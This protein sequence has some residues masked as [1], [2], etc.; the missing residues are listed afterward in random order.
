MDQGTLSY[1]QMQYPTGTQQRMKAAMSTIMKNILLLDDL[2]GLAAGIWVINTLICKNMDFMNVS[3][4]N[5]LSIMF[6][7]RQMNDDG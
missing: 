3:S 1:L 6:L 2:Y 5:K 4:L 7:K